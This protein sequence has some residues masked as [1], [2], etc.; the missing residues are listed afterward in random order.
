MKWKPREALVETETCAPGDARGPEVSPSPPPV[1]T[2][3]SGDMVAGRYR[4]LRFIAEGAMGEVYE[5]EDLTLRERVALKLIRPELA[6]Q[7]R[8]LE[9][10]TR[11]LLLARRVTHPGVCRV[12]DLGRHLGAG[13]DGAAREVVFL[14]ME[15]LAGR[16]L[17][18]HL[19]QRGRLAPGE[20]LE[21]A[22]QLAAALDAA[23]AAQVIHRD[24]KSGNVMLVPG[25]G[26]RGGTRVVVTDFGL[27]RGE[28][29]QEDG[30]VSQES[31]FQGSPAYMS[32][33]QVEGRPLSLASDLYSFGVVLF[34][35]VTG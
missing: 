23:H 10:F 31:Y 27:A 9:R 12:F 2:L 11:E 22:R 34:E 35:L 7:P 32:P 29:L 20:V 19:A 17:R 18:E 14:T 30:S 5:V 25:A 15:L 13:P 1:R 16:T 24:F 21:L 6:S 28:V 8:A 3:A 33:E 26:P 4:V